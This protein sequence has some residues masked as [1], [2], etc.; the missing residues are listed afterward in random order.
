MKLIISVTPVILALLLFAS[1]I[2]AQDSDSP[3]ITIAPSILE[4]RGSPTETLED[5]ISITNNTDVP[6]PITI[7]MKDYTVDETGMPDYFEDTSPWS[8]RDWITIAPLD[9]I[10]ESG[11]TR[12]IYLSITIPEKAQ[13][14][15]HIAVIFFKPVLP[16]DYFDAESA[17]VIPNI[18]GIISL[19]VWTEDSVERDDFLE[20]Q[21]FVSTVPEEDDENVTFSTNLFN[22]DVYFH[23]VAGQIRVYNIFDHIVHKERVEGVTLLPE[24]LRSV[25]NELSNSLPFGR[26]RAE[27]VIDEGT[28]TEE[29]SS[30]SFWIPPTPVEIATGLGIIILIGAIM[31]V[32]YLLIKNRKNLRKSLR[33][34]LRKR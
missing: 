5:S 4:L 33:V 17:H 14:G 31:Y 19:D 8:P 13:A 2:Q 22:D 28:P 1:S 32:I 21:K 23:R 29:R 11:A 7:E 26:Y 15:S 6:L 24:K 34:L 27:L 20:I 3:S 16:P 12:E 30:T 25:T 18:G 10:V 9:L